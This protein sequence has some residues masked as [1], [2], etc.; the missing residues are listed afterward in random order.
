MAEPEKKTE[1]SQKKEAVI[2]VKNMTAQTLAIGGV[3]IA[4][5]ASAAIDGWDAIKN[6]HVIAAWLKNGVI[7][8]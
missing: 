3:T 8:V 7:A 4:P 5:G 1:I 2:S 6:T